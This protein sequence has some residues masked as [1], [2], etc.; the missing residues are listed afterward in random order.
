MQELLT[1]GNPNFKAGSPE[2]FSCHYRHGNAFAVP[3]IPV[4]VHTLV[5]YQTS[6]KRLANSGKET[7]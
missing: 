4:I 1:A 7:C 5:I 2:M 6:E 3:L